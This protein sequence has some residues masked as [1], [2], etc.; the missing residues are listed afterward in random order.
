MNRN[1]RNTSSAGSLDLMLDILCNVFGSVILIACLLA[2][3]PRHSSFEPIWPANE[4][5]T[6]LIERRIEFAE[7]EIERT[8]TLIEKLKDSIDPELAKMM[9]RRD[10][11][12][13]TLVMLE[14][15]LEQLSSQEEFEAEARAFIALGRIED[16][17]E[18]LTTMKQELAKLKAIDEVGDEKIA[19]LKNRETSLKDKLKEWEQGQVAPVRLPKEKRPGGNP[20]PVIVR[21]G[22][23]YP[24]VIGANLR[25][26]PAVGRLALDEDAFRARPLKGKG[27]PLPDGKASLIATLRAAKERGCYITAYVYGD[28]HG[29]FQELKS[30]I[31]ECQ[32]SYGLEFK[33]AGQ[34]LN[35]AS[36]GTSPPK[37]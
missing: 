35:F 29:Q 36:E 17:R 32:L 8:R 4:A 31:A 34:E 18:H 2:I 12:K 21:H 10:S 22:E 14:E 7:K 27:A 13:E 9:E 15:E 19:Y 26:N 5:R 20:F 3:L 1:L 6:Q 24:L 25:D 16:L 11:L 33:E 23:I 30:L 37:L 28:S